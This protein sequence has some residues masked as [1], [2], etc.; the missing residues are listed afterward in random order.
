MNATQK[1][2]IKQ[3]AKASP[4]HTTGGKKPGKPAATTLPASSSTPA[5]TEKKK[6][7]WT[8]VRERFADIKFEYLTWLWPNVWLDGAM[9]LLTGSP[10]LG[11]TFVASHLAAC[12]STG[13]KWPDGSGNAP[14]GDVVF[15]SA[16]DSVASVL[17]HRVKAAGGDEARIHRWVK[18]TIARED[19]TVDAAEITLEDIELIEDDIAKM[20]N[21]KLVIFDPVTSFL[22]SAD[23]ND[24]A[25]VR[26]VLG[27]LVELAESK[28]FCVLL[29]THDKKMNVAAINSPMGST[30]FT[31]LPRVVH[32]L[33][34]DPE[35]E[36]KKK[37]LLLPIKNN[38][39][40]DRTG[41]A[42]EIITPGG[43]GSKSSIRWDEDREH[44]TADEVKAQ[45][46]KQMAF[47]GKEHSD[48]ETGKRRQV[49]LLNAL[50]AIKPEDDG[51]IPIAS[52]KTACGMSSST[53]GSTIFELVQAKI[54]EE[55]Y[56]DKELPN[57]AKVSGGKCLVR[58]VRPNF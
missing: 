49:K 13:A 30:A 50:D 26:R 2:K 55:R 57:G 31:A 17:K 12:V 20:E 51:W 42:F 22:G 36:T 35:D 56:I 5:A 46:V 11:K 48:E 27:R 43:M 54:V 45:A 16:E 52:L 1:A 47:A 37:R 6:P 53:L 23:A 39:G 7:E 24:N 25:E 18:K 3:A 19:G 41:L 29:I 4:T 9:N 10:G 28:K 44:R 38:H 40:D 32:G 15:M 34:R 14:L 33:F 8:L 21:V 58:R